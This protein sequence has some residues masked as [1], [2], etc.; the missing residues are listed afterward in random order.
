MWN[1][2]V[3]VGKHFRDQLRLSGFGVDTEELIIKRISPLSM[4]DSTQQLVC[5]LLDFVSGYLASN[6]PTKEQRKS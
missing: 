6:Y 3:E 4:V 1:Q 5:T 2:W